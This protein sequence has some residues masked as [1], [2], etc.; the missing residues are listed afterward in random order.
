MTSDLPLFTIVTSTLNSGATLARCLNSVRCQIGVSFEHLIADGASSDDTLEI[1]NR[2]S[3][4]YPLRLACS[5][6][7]VCLYQAWNRAL[8]QARGHWI[9]FLGSDDYLI[10][11]DVLCSVAELVRDDPG[12]Q[13]CQFI[14][15]DTLNAGEPNWHDYKPY[16][17]LRR[18]RGL[19]E[20][21]TSVFINAQLFRQGHR[22]DES[23]RICSDHKFF[24][25]HDLHG[26]SIYLPITMIA[27][28]QGGISSN[29]NYELIH[30]LERRR[31]LSELNLSRPWFSE[32]YYWLRSHQPRLRVM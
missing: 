2:F 20:F 11:D 10:S 25:Q 30:Y 29:A 4:S 7:D 18:L 12:I 8:D 9:L 26:N 21:P 14:Y 16:G 32:W 24:A 28:Q 17:Q 13:S 31:M 1:I 3:Q 27:F 15:G 5:A 23:Y 22:F 6:P 19:T